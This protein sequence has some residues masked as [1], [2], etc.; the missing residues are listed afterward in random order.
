MYI[1]YSSELV[2]IFDKDRLTLKK[3]QNESSGYP[4]QENICE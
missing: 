1:E 3:K 4:L 2:W